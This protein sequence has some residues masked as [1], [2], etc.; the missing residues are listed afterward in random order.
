MSAG[1]W[2]RCCGLGI[3]FANFSGPHAHWNFFSAHVALDTETD[4]E[5]WVVGTRPPNFLKAAGYVEQTPWQ[6]ATVGNTSPL[7]I[8]PR[9]LRFAYKVDPD[10]ETITIQMT[11]EMR[12]TFLD[13]QWELEYELTYADYDTLIAD[14]RL[15]LNDYQTSAD[16][17][18]NNGFPFATDTQEGW[19][20]IVLVWPRFAA[21][22][23]GKRLV[24]TAATDTPIKSRTPT[25]DTGFITN[26]I[27]LSWLATPHE[28]VFDDTTYVE[29]LSDGVGVRERWYEDSHV[30]TEC[31]T[32]FTARHYSAIDEPVISR[33]EESWAAI[34]RYLLELSFSTA[35]TCGGSP[36]YPNVR[37]AWQIS[38]IWWKAFE[39]DGVVVT[40]EHKSPLTGSGLP[41]ATPVLYD[42]NVFGVRRALQEY[43]SEDPEASVF[44][45]T[46]TLSLL[47]IE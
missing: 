7:A 44:P 26:P 28:F 12:R 20:D 32:Y 27:N 41:V 39:N 23:S 47:P 11:M 13:W 40:T 24:V 18:G 19:G 33:G 25:A 16:H 8:S 14:G 9:L 43:D 30:D 1:H 4:D 22:W 38:G 37:L 35:S 31:Y 10:A 45:I 17:S 6:G 46:Y 42:G 29:E 21:D 36:S 5:G 2:C 34:D 15:R 3:A